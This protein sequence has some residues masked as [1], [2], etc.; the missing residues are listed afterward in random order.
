MASLTTQVTDSLHGQPADGMHVEVFWLGPND[1]IHP[2]REM[3]TGPDGRPSRPAM[4]GREFERGE[5][6]LRFRVGDYFRAFSIIEAE[7]RFLGVIAV[8]IGIADAE[9]DHHVHL[10]VSPWSYTVFRG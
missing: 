7:P 6:E 4:V 10:V 2:I 8:R 1:A 3:V 5:Y 9:Q